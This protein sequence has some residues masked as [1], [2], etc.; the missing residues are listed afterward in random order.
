MRWVEPDEPTTV[1]ELIA[2]ED[3]DGDDGL[4]YRPPEA[5]AFEQCWF[6]HWH[7]PSPQSWAAVVGAL[8]LVARTITAD[9]AQ[10]EPS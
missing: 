8:A 7:D 4:P 2:A 9:S 10:E 1:E 6:E 3:E 5:E